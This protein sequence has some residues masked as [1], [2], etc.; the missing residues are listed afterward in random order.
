MVT[1]V[2]EGPAR[3]YGQVYL[4]DL[5]PEIGSSSSLG[6]ARL[7]Y[8][9]QACLKL[10]LT[11]SFRSSQIRCSSRVGGFGIG[12]RLICEGGG[13]EY[14]G[15]PKSSGCQRS[16]ISGITTQSARTR[17]PVRVS[18]RSLGLLNH[19]LGLNLE[20]CSM[21]GGER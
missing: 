20:R 14:P 18:H 10:S 6:N 4:S 19:E 12:C 17:S 11:S 1:S 8:P 13:V 9:L 15:S 2:S 5:P 16:R 21:D 3:V 7:L